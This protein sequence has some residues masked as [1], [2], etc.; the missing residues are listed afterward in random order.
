MLLSQI[1]YGKDTTIGKGRFKFSKIEQIEIDATSNAFMTLSPS[2][3]YKI[4]AKEIFYEPFTKFGKHG[5]LFANKNPFKKPL[6][7]AKSGAVV[8]YDKPKTLKFIGSAIKGYSA[9]KN[10]VHQGY[11]ITLP[12]RGLKL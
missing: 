2:N 11:S 8:V 12:I 1:G 6:L 3:L 10:S 7:L 5:L 9:Y 4:E